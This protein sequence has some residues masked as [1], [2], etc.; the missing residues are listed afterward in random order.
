MELICTELPCEFF[1]R[2]GHGNF[3]SYLALTVIL[4][5]TVS[6]NP[7]L[8]PV[9]CKMY[10]HFLF[11][12]SVFFFVSRRASISLKIATSSISDIVHPGRILFR[13]S[14]STLYTSQKRL[15]SFGAPRVKK[16]T[17]STSLRKKEPISLKPA[18]NLARKPAQI[19]VAMAMSLEA[20]MK[21]RKGEEVVST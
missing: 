7:R 3:H 10:G 15:A 21:I 6:T 1:H 16:N 9:H 2:Q 18:P 20:W 14:F 13:K 5:I 11:G 12:S 17:S 19:I 8:F 4:T